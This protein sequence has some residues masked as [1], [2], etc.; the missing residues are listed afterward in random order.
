MNAQRFVL[1]ASC[2]LTLLPAQ[3]GAFDFVVTRYDDPVPDGC[4]AADCSLREAV[5]AANTAADADRI[6]LSAGTYLLTR[7]GS[8]EDHS[9]TGDLDV[10]QDLEILG[11]GAQLT[12]I[13]AA[14]LGDD[15][16]HSIPG[17]SDLVLRKLAVRDSDFRGL[18]LGS[19]V[20]LVEDC[21]FR[22]NGSAANHHGI[23]TSLGSTLTLRR[24]TVTGSA[25]IGLLVNQGTAT[26]ENV[27]L[28]GNAG[29]EL[30]ANA[31]AGGVTCT[32][33]TLFDPADGDPEVGLFNATLTLANSIVAGDCSLGTG[34][35][36]DSLGGNV[37]SAGNTCQLDQAS[38]VVSVS[39]GTLSLAALADNGGAGG[40]R[41]HLP[42]AAG[43]ADG[44]ANDALCLPE[45]QRG[46]VR[47]T[48]CESGAVERTGAVI[49]RFIFV[50]DFLQ[51]STGAWSDTV[52]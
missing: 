29:R 49:P 39:A 40:T 38:D 13:D 21:E 12:A 23:N 48:N 43:A 51:G 26:L 45:D 16:I 32:H 3:A 4:L 22:D 1:F 19:G 50:D 44:A 25:D 18:V 7:V 47:E 42:G 52:P 14:G 28:S 8:G 5:I 17:L 46:V 6:L 33:C 37:E 10:R 27:T 9:A 2:L 24:S 11:R 36:I 35:A 30:V 41:T 31:S 20:H 34:G 15:A